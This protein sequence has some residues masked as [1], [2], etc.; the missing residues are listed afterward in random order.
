MSCDLVWDCHLRIY[1]CSDK[2]SKTVCVCVCVYV[3]LFIC[4][5]IL[6]NCWQSGLGS[7]FST[8]ECVWLFLWQDFLWNLFIKGALSRRHGSSFSFCQNSFFFL[9]KRHSCGGERCLEEVFEGRAWRTELGFIS[10]ATP[11]SPEKKKTHFNQCES[12]VDALFAA[13]GCYSFEE[14]VLSP[15]NLKFSQLPSSRL[16]SSAYLWLRKAV[17][18]LL[19]IPEFLQQVF[20]LFPN[21]WTCNR[22][23]LRK[24]NLISVNNKKCCNIINHL[25]V[26]LSPLSFF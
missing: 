18:L 25:S 21:L 14:F 1:I 19:G 12:P 26:F 20:L 3:N 15:V 4:V 7:L 22:Y 5:F 10:H 23:F 6:P 2:R 16:T 9:M 13:L 24:C 17:Y 8:S 11:H